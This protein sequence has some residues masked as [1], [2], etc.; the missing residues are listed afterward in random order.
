MDL[1]EFQS[2]QWDMLFELLYE[3]PKKDEG[4]SELAEYERL[5][6]KLVKLRDITVPDIGDRAEEMKESET[7]SEKLDKIED[8][9]EDYK[10]IEVAVKDL[11]KEYESI[12]SDLIKLTENLNKLSERN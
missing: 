11:V 1:I 8:E 2:K 6:E 12:I 4:R 3:E 9:I 7:D 10:G 5:T